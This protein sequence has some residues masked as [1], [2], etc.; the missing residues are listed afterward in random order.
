MYSATVL[1]SQKGNI[2]IFS[3]T[4]YNLKISIFLFSQFLNKIWNRAV[5]L[6]GKEKNL[7]L[8]FQ[9]LT[10]DSRRHPES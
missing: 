5:I 7:I 1:P 2:L 10:Q 9:Y 6:M 8:T 3:P 4:F